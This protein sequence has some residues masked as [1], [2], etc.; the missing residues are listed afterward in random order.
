MADQATQEERSEREA[1]LRMSRGISGFAI[2]L[3]GALS[4]LAAVA[5]IAKE[6]G[7]S[8]PVAPATAQA[9]EVN[10]AMHDPGCHWFQTN[11]GMKKDLTVTGTANL[12]NS[13]EAALVVKAPS[14]QQ[15]V[16]VGGDV[17][18]PAGN[19][20]ITMVGQAPDDN[21]LHLTVT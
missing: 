19:Y 8:T 6:G 12:R 4:F 14:G 3:I 1:H 18:L 10:V 11:Q 5:Y 15:K 16:P 21:T 13:D 7:P 20:T 2:G 9:A 17:Q